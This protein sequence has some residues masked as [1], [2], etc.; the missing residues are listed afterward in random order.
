METSIARDYIFLEELPIKTS[1]DPQGK[2][3]G[4]QFIL[5]FSNDEFIVVKSKVISS[6]QIYTFKRRLK[7]LIKDKNILESYIFLSDCYEK[8]NIERPSFLCLPEEILKNQI[9]MRQFL[10]EEQLPA[11]NIY[12][13]KAIIE[14]EKAI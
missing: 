1:Y 2:D 9:V 12:I 8:L 14:N 6:K 13:G 3:I 4:I 5:P 10:E 7:N 11:Y